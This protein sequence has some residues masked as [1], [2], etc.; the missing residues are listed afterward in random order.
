MKKILLTIL[1][2]LCSINMTYAFFEPTYKHKCKGCQEI[3]QCYFVKVGNSK[4]KDCAELYYTYLCKDCFDNYKK[5]FKKEG[6]TDYKFTKMDTGRDMTNDWQDYYYAIVY[7]ENFGL[8]YGNITDK[9]QEKL[10]LKDDYE[11]AYTNLENFLK[12]SGIETEEWVKILNATLFKSDYCLSQPW[13]S[14]ETLIAKS[15]SS[16]DL[17]NNNIEEKLKS[18]ESFLEYCYE[19]KSDNKWYEKYSKEYE[20]LLEEQKKQ[21]E[22]KNKEK[23]INNYQNDLKDYI[24]NYTKYMIGT[25]ERNSFDSY[26][27]CKILLEQG[28]LTFSQNLWKEMPCQTKVTYTID[29]AKFLDA[30]KPYNESTFNLLTIEERIKRLQ[31]LGSEKLIE[32]AKTKWS[33]TE[34]SAKSLIKT[35]ETMTPDEFFEQYSISNTYGQRG[36]MVYCFEQALDL[37]PYRDES[38][39]ATSSN[40]ATNSN[41]KGDK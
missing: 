37:S 19:H 5:D 25:E 32:A 27:Y 11:K 24:A 30:K 13:G 22:A 4:K 15:V 8:G 7:Y 9:I 38:I 12:D 40:I 14:L 10:K 31:A 3:K 33:L 21:E 34:K 18:N 29:K 41:M 23:L 2:I 35:I 16:S 20:L 26:E 1:F 17:I 6:L 36:N 39:I 28:S